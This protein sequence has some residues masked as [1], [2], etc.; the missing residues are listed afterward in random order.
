MGCAGRKVDRDRRILATC[1]PGEEN[2]GL[3]YIKDQE[4][5]KADVIVQLAG[6]V[7]LICI[8]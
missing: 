3:S 2:Q 1:S 6:Y 7:K 8:D 5:L 4:A